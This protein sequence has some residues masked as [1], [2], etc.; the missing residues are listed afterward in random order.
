MSPKL[1]LKH[2][3]KKTVL[4]KCCEQNDKDK[5]DIF[6]LINISV[7]HFENSALIAASIWIQLMVCMKTNF[8][9]YL[10]KFVL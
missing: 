7:S 5:I 8:N 1:N 2:L 9:D 10:E 3:H 4:Y 6:C